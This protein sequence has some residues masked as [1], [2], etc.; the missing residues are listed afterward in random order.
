MGVAPNYIAIN[1]TTGYQNSINATYKRVYE[2]KAKDKLR[3]ISESK[4]TAVKSTTGGE[5]PTNGQSQP[6]TPKA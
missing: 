4:R 5:T 6:Q 3:Q 1:V 2:L